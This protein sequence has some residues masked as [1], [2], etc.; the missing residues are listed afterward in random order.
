VTTTWD[1]P[2]AAPEGGRWS[3]TLVLS[4]V[5]HVAGFGAALGLPRLLPRGSQGPPVYVVD[6]VALPA[7]PVTVAPAAP[8]PQA[9]SSPAP[10]KA[11][12]PIALP[13]RQPKKAP[14]KKPPAPREDE[15]RSE[16]KKPDPSRE[17]A[18]DTSPPGTDA[19]RAAATT[20]PAA[21]ALPGAAGD[22]G[23]RPGGAGGTGGKPTDEYNFYFSLLRRKIDAAWKKP[24][25]PTSQ[26]VGSSAT[27]TLTLSS[28]GRVTRLDLTRPSGFDSL[29]RSVLRA[30]QDAEPF[31]PFPY[32][33]GVDTLTVNFEFVLTP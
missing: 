20:G 27:I 18:K 3:T 31:P 2:G 10:P 6:L 8:P 33:L 16:P 13:E 24:L 1:P 19:G 7:G 28:S 32:Q 15:K 22:A 11:E 25:D 4:L 14:P 12:K 21:G 17:T 30:V 29:D 26:A 23:T 5:L 9:K